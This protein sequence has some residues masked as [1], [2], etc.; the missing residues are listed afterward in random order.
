MCV[1]VCVCVFVCVDVFFNSTVNSTV[2]SV[3]EC[4][5]LFALG[6]VKRALLRLCMYDAHCTQ[7]Y[8]HSFFKIN[9]LFHV[10]LLMFPQ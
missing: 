9:S 3:R 5:A 10:F 6:D 7:M 8:E 2:C 4:S 1:C